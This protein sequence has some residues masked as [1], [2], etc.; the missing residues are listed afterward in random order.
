MVKKVETDKSE[1]VKTKHPR[2][3]TKL[4]PK[5]EFAKADN[6]AKTAKFGTSVQS[7]LIEKVT[8]LAEQSAKKPNT[9]VT[10][11]L[12]SMFE[13]GKFNV[14]FEKKQELKVTSYNLPTDMVKAIEKIHKTTGQPK[15]EIFNTLL[16]TALKEYF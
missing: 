9:V 2:K 7:G 6:I 1:G 15:A 4:T 16:A 10:E 5:K 14:E 13:N 3:N 8:V 12:Q 11:L